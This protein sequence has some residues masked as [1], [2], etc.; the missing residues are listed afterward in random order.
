MH[1]L[2]AFKVNSDFQ[3]SVNI[4]LITN[5]LKSLNIAKSENINHFEIMQSE[6]T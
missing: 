6:G 3:S 2:Q 5:K 1:S 4:Y